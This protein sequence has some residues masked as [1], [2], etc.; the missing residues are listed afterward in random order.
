MCMEFVSLLKITDKCF[1]SERSAELETMF[2]FN[3]ANLDLSL[4]ANPRSLVLMLK[5]KKESVSSTCC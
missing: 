3:Q 5:K 2:F 4:P 1:V